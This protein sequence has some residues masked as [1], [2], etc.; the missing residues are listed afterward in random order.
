VINNNNNNNNSANILK[1][2]II[3]IKYK[4]KLLFTKLPSDQWHHFR[5][6][7]RCFGIPHSLQHKEQPFCD[8]GDITHNHSLLIARKSSVC[9]KLRFTGPYKSICAMCQSKLCEKYNCITNLKSPDRRHYRLRNWDYSLCMI[10]YFLQVSNS[11][12]NRLRTLPLLATLYVGDPGNS[13]IGPVFCSWR[14]YSRI[15]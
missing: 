1:S 6:N 2:R 8:G 12:D 14:T 10:Y 15:A 7:V 4:L 13:I 9:I 5:I 3:F 11:V